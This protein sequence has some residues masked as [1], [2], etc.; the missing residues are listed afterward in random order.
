M[1]DY[2][3]IYILGLISII[4]TSVFLGT[5]SKSTLYIKKMKMKKSKLFLDFTLLAA[6]L[7]DIGLIIYV[8]ILVKE[9]ISSLSY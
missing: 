6:S 7:I 3:W 1:T 4:A 2:F 5:M 8:F 9:Q